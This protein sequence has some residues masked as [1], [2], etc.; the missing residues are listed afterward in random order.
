MRRVLR[1]SAQ[2]KLPSGSGKTKWERRGRQSRNN[3]TNFGTP[4]ASSS[5]VSQ[6]LVDAASLFWTWITFGDGEVE[7]V[8]LPFQTPRLSFNL[9]I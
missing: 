4:P 6:K 5:H 7:E 9:S 8:A 1:M 2:G 3:R